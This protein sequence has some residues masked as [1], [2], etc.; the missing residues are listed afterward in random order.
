MCLII[1]KRAGDVIHPDWLADFHG[2]NHDGA[3]VMWFDHTKNAVQVEKVCAP[4]LGAW[5]AFYAKH[6]AWRDCVIH[7]RMRTH[8]EIN[9]LNTHPY[10]VAAGIWLMH[11][12]VL[13]HG[14]A[15]D[16]SRSDTWHYIR[17]ILRPKL[18]K[19]PS[20]MHSKKFQR[21][22][23][24]DI[25]SNN[26]FVLL[27]LDGVPVVINRHSGVEWNGLWLSNTY[28]WSSGAAGFG[29]GYAPVDND[30]FD[31]DEV[32]ALADQESSLDDQFM[33]QLARARSGP[34]PK[35]EL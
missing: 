29:Y 17:D 23:A 14:N 24:D 19:R 5:L 27:G 34:L 25:G 28:A 13:R 9:E 3:G 15:K 18:S 2:R 1:Q 26:R 35:G 21:E 22:I 8:G 10:Y 7:L 30:E 32:N 4:T 11:N 16:T 31:E 6:A 33:A 12:G 20:L